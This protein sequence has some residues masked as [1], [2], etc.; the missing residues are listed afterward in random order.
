MPRLALPDGSPPVVAGRFL[1]AMSQ[2]APSAVMNPGH[3]EATDKLVAGA[4]LP[5]RRGIA[6]L[7]L[8]SFDF[9]VPSVDLEHGDLSMART[10]TSLKTH[11][12][13]PLEKRHTIACSKV[14]GR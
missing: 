11:L 9:H 7:V 1:D 2:T 5:N 14:R 12:G 13:L 8:A 4:D 3:V 10:R 6:N